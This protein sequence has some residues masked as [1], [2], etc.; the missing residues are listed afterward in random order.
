MGPL[1]VT[2]QPC[3]LVSFDIGFRALGFNFCGK[4]LGLKS[5]L[6]D[7]GSHVWLYNLQKK[8]RASISQL[9]L[10]LAN[11]PGVYNRAWD[12]RVR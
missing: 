8:K 10:V 7:M 12:W 4:Y 11:D 2:C 1:M 5:L 6:H 9:L 3:H